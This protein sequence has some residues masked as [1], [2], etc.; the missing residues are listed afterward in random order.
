M[1]ET[2]KALFQEQLAQRGLYSRLL[3]TEEAAAATGLSQYELRMG[4]KS[5]KYPCILGGDEKKQFRKMKW[6]LEALDAAIRQQMTMH[7]EE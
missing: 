4:A 6:N 1:S 2:V 5:G 7:Q 3:T